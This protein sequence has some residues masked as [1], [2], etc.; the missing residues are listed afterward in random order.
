[1]DGRPMVRVHAHFGSMGWSAAGMP[2]SSRGMA[3]LGRFSGMGGLHCRGQC[4]LMGGLHCRC[5]C[6]L[7]FVVNFG[8]NSQGSCKTQHEVPDNPT[9][10]KERRRRQVQSHPARKPRQPHQ[11]RSIGNSRGAMTGRMSRSRSV[12]RAGIGAGRSLSQAGRG[13]C[14]DRGVMCY[15]PTTWMRQPHCSWNSWLNYHGM[16]LLRLSGSS[17]RSDKKRST[18]GLAS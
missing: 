7:C 8:N 10:K 9:K 13:A 11:P 16:Q 2:D 6:Q 4:Q 14:H 3:M 5:Q 18:M 15:R 17:A 1:M 12:I